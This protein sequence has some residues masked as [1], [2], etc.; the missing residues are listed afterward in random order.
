MTML[1]KAWYNEVV[2]IGEK[3]MNSKNYWRMQKLSIFYSY[4]VFIDSIDYWADQL[5]IKYKVKVAFD[6]EYYTSG[7]MV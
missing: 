3:Y 2:R 1:K 5:F 4:Y 6:K 7:Q